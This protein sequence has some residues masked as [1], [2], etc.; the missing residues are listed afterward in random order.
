MQH[1][2][3]LGPLLFSININDHSTISNTLTIYFNTEDFT[4]DNLPKYITSE[5]DKVDGKPIEHVKYFRF[6]DIL[7]DENLTWKCHI[8]MV[9]NKLSKVIRILN[10]LNLFT[11]TCIVINQYIIPLLHPT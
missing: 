11:Y 8:N 10:R 9:A 3:I 4:K 6:L 7:F 1:G 2:S 5:L